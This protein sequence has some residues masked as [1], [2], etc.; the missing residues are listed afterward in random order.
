MNTNNILLVGPYAPRKCGIAMHIVQLEQ[1]L[2]A[3]GWTVDVLA[4][5][6]CNATYRETVFGGFNVLKLLKYTRQYKNVNIHFD[7]G[8]FFHA[9]HDIKRVLNIFPLLALWFLFWR[10]KNINVVMHEPPPARF[11]LQRTILQKWVWHQ[12]SR[13]TFFTNRER[14]TFLRKYNLPYRADQY[15]VEE[16]NRP[17]VKFSNLSKDEARS[18]LGVSKEKINFLCIGFIQ[19]NKGFERLAQIFRERMY[20]TLHLYIVGSVKEGD[21]EAHAYFATL[22]NLCDGAENI[23]LVNTYLSDEYFDI[24]ISAADYVVIPYRRISN[25]AVLG[26]ARLLDTP[27]IVADVGGLGDQIG[28]L[29]ALFSTDVELRAI[30]DRIAAHRQ[31]VESKLARA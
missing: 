19:W 24:W 29:D 5:L 25:S 20:E 16:L 18:R 26:R 17:Y 4:P 14:D 30:V 31:L 8:E 2:R 9:G 22:S 12:A 15:R 10:A 13:I 28:E 7:F 1:G 6:D 27:A 23:K 11:G 3:E 21:K